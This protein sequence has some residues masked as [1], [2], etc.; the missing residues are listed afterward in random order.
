MSGLG[1]YQHFKTNND[2]HTRLKLK[3]KLSKAMYSKLPAGT[4][5]PPKWVQN[6]EYSATTLVVDPIHTKITM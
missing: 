2:K 3:Q 4:M 6:L 1:G 5:V